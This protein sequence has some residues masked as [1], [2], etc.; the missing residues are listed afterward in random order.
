MRKKKGQKPNG[1]C[2]GTW[3]FKNYELAPEPALSDEAMEAAL[4]KGFIDNSNAIILKM[5]PDMVLPPITFTFV[6]DHNFFILESFPVNQQDK[7]ATWKLV[8]YKAAVENPRFI[9]LIADCRRNATGEDG[10]MLQIRKRGQDEVRLIWMPFTWRDGKA[11]AGEMEYAFLPDDDAD[12][13]IPAW[14]DVIEQKKELKSMMELMGDASPEHA[15][16]MFRL[17]FKRGI[18]TTQQCRDAY[19]SG[20]LSDEEWQG[21]VG[22]SLCMSDPGN[23]MWQPSN[24][25]T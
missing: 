2:L 15:K 3:R 16:C 20:V 17:L 13:I 23:P 19:D 11:V 9:F 5:T 25:Q 18:K 7:D 12:N 21:L 10:F 1:G 22:E 14:W 4:V 6:D 8:K 24:G